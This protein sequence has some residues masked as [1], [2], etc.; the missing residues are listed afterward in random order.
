MSEPKGR[1]FTQDSLPT[2]KLERGDHKWI[3]RPDLTGSDDLM[4]VQVDMPPG[5]GH[6]FHKHPK[7]DEVIY[8]ISG[9]AE[10]WIEKKSKI[11]KAGDSVFI[12]KDMVHATFND[13]DDTLS[14]LA[15]LSPATDYENATV[16]VFEDE[17][18]KSL[19]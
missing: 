13:G 3:S 6:S 14:F 5:Q 15:I 10:Q 2:D 8:V 11:L 1:F 19:R 16:D 17:P 9:T 4:M 18:W 7:M 12:P